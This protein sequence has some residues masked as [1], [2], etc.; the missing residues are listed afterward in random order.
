MKDFEILS[1]SS[2][3]LVPSFVRSSPNPSSPPPAASSLPTASSD[4]SKSHVPFVF[5]HNYHVLTSSHVV[6]PW[7]WRKYYSDPWLEFVDEKHTFYTI[8]VRHDNGVFET[9]A[10]LIPISFH[11]PTRDVAVLHLMDE[12]SNVEMMKDVGLQVL[13]LAPPADEL[14]TGAALEFL[15]HD[16][17]GGVT[18]DEDMRVPVPLTVRG[19]FSHRTPH[20]TFGRPERPLVDGMCGGPVLRAASKRVHGLLEGIVPQDHPTASLRGLASFIESLEIASFLRDLERGRIQPLV[21]GDALE[22]I[23]R[24]KDPEKLNLE[25]ILKKFEN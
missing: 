6:A 13:D 10:E 25:S 20:Q 24:D 2:A 18:A 8:E 22:V 5:Q 1:R 9:Q 7:K 21:G 12:A 3:F 4:P 19:T 15:G 23:A 14:E 16:M 11:H 17:Q